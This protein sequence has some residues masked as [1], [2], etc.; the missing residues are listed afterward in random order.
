MMRSLPLFAAATLAG[1]FLRY[2]LAGRPWG[3]FAANLLG[4]FILGTGRLSPIAAAA[5]CGAL[6]TLSGMVLEASTMPLSRAALY[7]LATVA[8]GFAAFAAGRSL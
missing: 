1:G 3:L 6:T 4:C 2:A 5:F 7:T 8:A